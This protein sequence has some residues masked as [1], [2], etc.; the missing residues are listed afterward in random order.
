MTLQNIFMGVE[1]LHQGHERVFSQFFTQWKIKA[2]N[3][4]YELVKLRSTPGS[5][6]AY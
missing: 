2:Q 4:V 3:C 1:T 6:S 5:T